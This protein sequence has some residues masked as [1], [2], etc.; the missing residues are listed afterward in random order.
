M[1]TIK[2]ILGIQVEKIGD[3]FFADAKILS[4]SPPI[5]KGA[6]EY[7]ALYDLLAKLMFQIGGP[8]CDSGHREQWIAA[9][10]N[11]WLDKDQ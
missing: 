8:K 4:G 10:Q 5:G 3:G 6:T 11:F 9:I 7:E 2:D 1:K